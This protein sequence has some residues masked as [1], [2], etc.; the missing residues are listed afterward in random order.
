MPGDKAT[1]PEVNAEI[2]VA[3]HYRAGIQYKRA[4]FD[5]TVQPKGQTVPYGAG[6]LGNQSS[7]CILDVGVVKA[8]VVAGTRKVGIINENECAI[9]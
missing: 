6:W 8:V 3:W 9:F 7:Q 5:Q 4:E 2:R 1:P